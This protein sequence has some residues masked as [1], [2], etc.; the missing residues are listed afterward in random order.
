M[1]FERTADPLPAAALSCIRWLFVIARNS[2]FTYKE[3]AVD[4]KR[5]GRELGS[6]ICS[7]VVATGD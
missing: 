4:V 3:Q 2:S 7:K 6:A 5:V 1:K